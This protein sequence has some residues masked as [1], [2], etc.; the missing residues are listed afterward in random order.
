M[1]RIFIADD[2][3]LFRN[4]LCRLIGEDKDY[5]IVGEASNSEEVFE[6]IGSASPDMILLDIRM[7]GKNGIEILKEIKPIYPKMK[8]VMLTSFEDYLTIKE[9]LNLGADGYL[10]KNTDP[11]LLMVI[12]KCIAHDFFVMEKTMHEILYRS[13]KISKENSYR[14][15]GINLDKNDIN[16]VKM[17]A[18]GMTNKEIGIALN[19]TEGTIKNKVSSILSR[20]NSVDRTQ[21][22]LFALKNNI[23]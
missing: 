22:T 4:M 2:Q 11:D 13:Y 6:N 5:L 15:E 3:L 23:I 20:T 7:P 12:L 14:Y 16:I 8:I 10:T 18:K 19:Y 9:A 21:L 17:I 1:I